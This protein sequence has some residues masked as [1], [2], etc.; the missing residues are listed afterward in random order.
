MANNKK[1]NFFTCRCCGKSQNVDQSVHINENYCVTCYNKE[2]IYRR[3]LQKLKMYKLL[4]KE[5]GKNTKNRRKRIRIFKKINEILLPQ[6]TL[7]LELEQ[8]DELLVERKRDVFK[9]AIQKLSKDYKIEDY[10]LEKITG[11]WIRRLKDIWFYKSLRLTDQVDKFIELINPVMEISEFSKDKLNQLFSDLKKTVKL[12]YFTYIKSRNAFEVKQTKPFFDYKDSYIKGIIKTYRRRLLK[13]TTQIKRFEYFVRYIAEEC[14]FQTTHDALKLAIEKYVRETHQ[15]EVDKIHKRMHE[16]INMMEDTELIP[17]I[18]KYIMDNHEYIFSRWYCNVLPFDKE[19]FTASDART[20]SRTD[21]V[22][23]LRY[24]FENKELNYLAEMLEE[25]TELLIKE[26]FKSKIER[27][28]NKDGWSEER[29]KKRIVQIKEDYN[30]KLKPE[31]L[32]KSRKKNADTAPMVARLLLLNSE[33][34]FNIILN[35]IIK[36]H[37]KRLNI[38]SKVRYI[39]NVLKSGAELKKSNHELDAFYLIQSREW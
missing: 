10:R 11:E 20:G 32:E 37:Y 30:N 28:K 22:V 9:E 34:A 21:F 39:T 8:I 27:Y 26:K 36:Y 7:S 17:N 24:K 14:Q 33:K 29:I 4:L 35:K 2:Q 23:K 16:D 19:R 25:T 18:A 5:Q 1:K 6:T 3:F 38:R 15:Q 12:P 31:N 13:K